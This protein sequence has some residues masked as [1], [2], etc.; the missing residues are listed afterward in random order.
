MS[1]V[2][3]PFYSKKVKKVLSE[4]DY[5]N[6]KKYIVSRNNCVKKRLILG[7]F[8]FTGLSRKYIASIK[9]SDFKFDN[10]V[11]KLIIWK[12][13]DAIETEIEIPLKM[14]LQ[15]IVNEYL[16]QLNKE[17]RLNKVVETSNENSISALVK[18][19]AEESGVKECSPTILSNTFISKALSK[20]NYIYEVSKLTLESITTVES[21][22]SMD[23]E[24]YTLQVSILNNF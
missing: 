15:L 5:T 21:H 10:G 18:K 19:I 17:E 7:L 14:E 22:I 9:N 6:L 16:Q 11:Y 1:Q 23:S 20:G 13:V 3:K 4:S 8:L 2:E 12:K 24:L